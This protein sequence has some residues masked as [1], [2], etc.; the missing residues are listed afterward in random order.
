MCGVLTLTPPVPCS[1]S[2]RSLSAHPPLELPSL[3]MDGLLERIWEQM[4]LVRVYTKRV[5]NK[6]DFA[7]PVVLTMDRGGTTVAGLCNQIHRSV[8]CDPLLSLAGV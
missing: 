3:N 1:L 2:A 6:P 5:G 4:A 7:T 8:R